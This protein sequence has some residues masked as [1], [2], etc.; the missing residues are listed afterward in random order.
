MKTVAYLRVSTGGQD[1][2]NQKLAILGYARRHRFTVARF[3][4]ARLSSRRAAARTDLPDDRGAAGGRS[5]GGQ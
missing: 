4:E 3:V 5:S 2:A 1:L